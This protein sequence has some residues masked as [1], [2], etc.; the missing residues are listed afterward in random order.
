MKKLGIVLL[1]QGLFLLSTINDIKGQK[2]V[3]PNLALVL[4]GTYPSYIDNDGY[5]TDTAKL[6]ESLAFNLSGSLLYGQFRTSKGMEGFLK[7][8]SLNVI[9]TP[10]YFH[11]FDSLPPNLD[12][13]ILIGNLNQLK[14]VPTSLKSLVVT[15]YDSDILP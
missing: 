5:L 3:D 14:K 12:T 10:F 15:N 8:K 13:L 4:R 7:L 6:A 2:I 11:T 9:L 1:L